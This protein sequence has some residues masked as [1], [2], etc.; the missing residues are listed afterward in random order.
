MRALYLNQWTEFA[1]MVGSFWNVSLTGAEYRSDTAPYANQPYW[2]KEKAQM[3]KALAD[4]ELQGIEVL[5]ASYVEGS[6]CGDAFVLFRKDEKLYEVNASH[7][8]CYG[9]LSYC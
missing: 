3:T 9:G 2:L 8:S 4:P 5:L 7:C 1:D 6:D